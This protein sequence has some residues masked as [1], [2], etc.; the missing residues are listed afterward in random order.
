MNAK[1]G[2][3][4]RDEWMFA[5]PLLHAVSDSTDPSGLG[6]IEVG[7]RRTSTSFEAVITTLKQHFAH[8]PLLATSCFIGAP[9][10]RAP[11]RLLPPFIRLVTLC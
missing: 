8:D 3:S 10:E 7:D 2:A 4:L 11:D 6:G 9:F 1:Y 5:L